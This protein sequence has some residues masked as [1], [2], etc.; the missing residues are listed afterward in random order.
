MLLAL[1]DSGRRICCNPV[2][3]A[4]STTNPN[5][6]T[7]SF[8]PRLRLFMERFI[9]ERDDL[10]I[11]REWPVISLQFDYSGTC[12]RSN[13]RRERFFVSTAKG[14]NAVERDRAA[15]VKLQCLLESFG[16][17]EIDQVSDMAA[18]YDSPADYL[19]QA[20][21][22][23][24]SF[25][26]FTAFAV[27]QLEALGCKV[28]I[29]PSY[30]FQVV[31]D[32]PPWQVIIEP[33]PGRI[34]WFGVQLGVEVDGK[35]IDLLPALLALIDQHAHGETLESML[36]LSARRR[37]IP[38]GPNRYLTVAPE[39]FRGLL[40]VVLEIHRGD[41][42]PMTRLRIDRTHA[43]SLARLERWT[44][45]DASSPPVLDRI[46]KQGRALLEP[47]SP[48][49]S[50]VQG[51]TVTL[52]PYQSEGVAWLGR[53]RDFG[54]SGIL[55]DDMGLGK[56]LQ[57]IAL[58]CQEHQNG[59]VDLPSLVVAPTSL[60]GNW[61]R[62]VARFCPALSCLVYHGSRRLDLADQ[63]AQT[64]VVVTT[65]P[66]L[67]R[68]LPQLGL[69]KFHYLV[70]D[71]AQAIKNPMSQAARAVKTLHAQHRLCLSG[72]PVENNL[73]ELWSIF[74]FLM[75]D[76]LG[77]KAAFQ[78]RFRAPIERDA[79]TVRLAA[80][81]ERVGPFVLRRMK[82]QVAKELPAKTELVRPVE[83]EGEQR[84]LYE[85]IRLAAHAEVRKAIQKK[86]VPGSAI[87]ILDALTKLR[88]VCCDPR[89]VR[90]PA[91]SSVDKSAKRRL[92]FELL[93]SQLREG[94]KVLVF[95]QFAQMLALLSEGLLERGIRHS[96]L[97]GKVVDRQSRIDLFQ[98]GKVDVFL[99][100]LKAG[101]TGL[102]LTRADTVVHYD[103]WWNAAAQAQATD[104]AHRIGQTRPVFVHNLI[105]AGSVEERMLAL[106]R[107]KQWL[108]DS[109]FAL[110]ASAA[111][112]RLELTEIEHLF[113]PLD[114]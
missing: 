85:S 46:L 24:H 38:I 16:A 74:D 29:D 39:R 8:L 55:A 109:L 111:A 98:E 11:E 88:Q 105:V 15:E 57:A 104:R 108:S 31:D 13:D 78:R 107:R 35:R 12:L 51:L 54:L 52:R 77:S 92:F 102:N 49:D 4:S 32:D 99:I 72:T 63:I 80:L 106:Q 73:D 41:Q 110:D 75:P 64:D 3:A 113:A 79:D 100:S 48:G 2:V 69:Q 66:I 62:E 90:L 1:V 91:A 96:C 86:G 44:G 70:L 97:T 10:E 94:R 67:I 50:P 93:S 9:V 37:A 101:G 26:S 36:R 58:L 33:E 20:T 59:R 65:Y 47:L 112:S 53:L 21:D 87:T 45:V 95:S 82:E 22:N 103:P 40:Q 84:D 17:V 89:L 56:T 7:D 6:G 25:C 30:P 18:P 5:T 81:R 14:V 76:L 43:A 68:D 19:V 23:V 61:A 83:I 34:D 28:T 114:G 27:P 42:L 71:E 60:V